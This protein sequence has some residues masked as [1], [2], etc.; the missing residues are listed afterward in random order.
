M[1]KYWRRRERLEK[2]RK[3]SNEFADF[4]E[5]GGSRSTGIVKFSN[6]FSDPKRSIGEKR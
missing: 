6:D 2:T 5:G 3:F 4:G 1:E